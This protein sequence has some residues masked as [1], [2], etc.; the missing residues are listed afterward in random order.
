MR[1]IKFIYR[2]NAPNEYVDIDIDNEVVISNGDS[3]VVPS[4]IY[5]PKYLTMSVEGVIQIP[6]IENLSY[7]SILNLLILI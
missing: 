5:N 4:N 1:R 2:N 6:W 3:I 7:S